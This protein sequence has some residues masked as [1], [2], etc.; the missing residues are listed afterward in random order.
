MKLLSGFTRQEKSWMMY[1]WA[2]SAYSVI[3]VTILPIFY[4]SLTEYSVG[5]V[6]RWGNSTSAAMLIIAVL[7]PLLGVLGDFQH[8]KKRLFTGFVVLG[9]LSCAAMATTPLLQQGGTGAETLGMIVL[10]LYIVATIGFA[11]ANV[12]YD[13]FLPEVTT[14]EKMDRV[15]I[16]GYGMGYIGGSTIPLVIFMAMNLAG[17]PMHLCLSIAFALTAVWWI[18]FTV[19]FWKNVHQTHFVPRE[20]GMFADS[21]RNLGDTAKA[22]FRNKPMLVFMLAYFFYIDG[23]GT[24]IHMSTSYGSAL[25]IDST[26]M[27]LA[28]LLVQV[29]GL[30]FALL[31]TRLSARFGARA[32]VGFGIVVYMLICLF[33]FS[34]TQA[35]QFWVLAVLVS[36]SQGGIQALSRS[37]YGKMIPDKNKS[38]EY[39]GFYDIFGKFSSIMG[40]ALFG[41]VAAYAG[42]VLMSEKGIVEAEASAETLAEISKQAA[43]YGVIAVLVIFIIGAAM[44]FVVLPRVEKRNAKRT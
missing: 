34:V 40:P 10:A 29:L 6:S 20:R 44:Y 8:W 39:F 23:V 17:V 21:V 16:M 4:N 5:A 18:A 11:G 41:A 22:I 35:W 26:Q 7:A 12:Y 13:G 9:A 33:A 1:D 2:N 38:G 37:V 36:T 24:I 25:G 14:P 31:Y 19:P 15:S 3:I 27:L 42:R 28:L 32:M 43:P 30:P